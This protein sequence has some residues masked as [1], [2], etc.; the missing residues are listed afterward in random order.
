MIKHAND[1]KN[2][3]L[4][5][6]KRLMSTRKRYFTV[7]QCFQPIDANKFQGVRQSTVVEKQNYLEAL[8]NQGHSMFDSAGEPVLASPITYVSLSGK[9]WEIVKMKVK[10]PFETINL[11][12]KGYGLIKQK[13]LLAFDILNVLNLNQPINVYFFGISNGGY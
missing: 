10:V 6:R 11:Q 1:N 2:L 5:K 3:N 13:I 12:F 9:T 4:L 8:R 7:P